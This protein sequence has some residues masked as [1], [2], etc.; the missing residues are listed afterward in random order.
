MS[1]PQHRFNFRMDIAVW[2]KLRYIAKNNFRTINKELEMLINKHIARH[3]DI[4][5]DILLHDA[6]HS[7]D[8]EP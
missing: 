8:K 5:G 7:K 4:N 1:K 2:H 3:E 6:E